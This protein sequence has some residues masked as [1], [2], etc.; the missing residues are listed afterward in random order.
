MKDVKQSR[1]FVQSNA[2]A[3]E[4]KNKEQATKDDNIF[5]LLEEFALQNKPSE[6]TEADRNFSKAFHDPKLKFGEHIPLL[7]GRD[8]LGYEPTITFDEGRYEV[9]D[10]WSRSQKLGE[11]FDF[12][13]DFITNR[14][15]GIPNLEYLGKPSNETVTVVGRVVKNENMDNPGNSID[16]LNTD[17]DNPNGVMKITVNLDDVKEKAFLFEGQVI[18][19][20]GIA[21]TS[22]TFSATRIIAP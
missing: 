5:T 18:G 19:V 14:E 2:T 13:K 16:L 21:E 7:T 20:E 11:Q 12:M 15:G 1:E 17:D 4:L 22:N 3:K 6:K 10:H 8:N 9:Y